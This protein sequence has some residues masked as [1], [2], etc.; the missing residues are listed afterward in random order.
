MI[1]FKR[2]SVRMGALPMFLFYLERLFARYI[3]L[4]S[5]HPIIQPSRVAMR[6]T[7]RA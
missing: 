7:G 5:A 1:L 4:R 2:S 6:A 3:T